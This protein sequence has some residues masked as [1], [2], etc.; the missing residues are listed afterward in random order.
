MASFESSVVPGLLLQRFT[1]YNFPEN[2]RAIWA[3]QNYSK[4]QE[5][6][7]Q[8][9]TGCNFPQNCRV[10]WVHPSK[11]ILSPRNCYHKVL[12]ASISYKKA[13][14]YFFTVEHSIA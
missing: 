7:S 14:N 10:I 2:C 6:L 3:L 11:I 8:G 9:F 1:N 12:L 13:L 5:L 4:S